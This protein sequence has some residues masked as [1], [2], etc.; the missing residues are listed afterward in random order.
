MSKPWQ[1][2]TSVIVSLETAVSYETVPS[3]LPSQQLTANYDDVVIDNY[4]LLGEDEYTKNKVGPPTA[5]I[6]ADDYDDI[7]LPNRDVVGQDKEPRSHIGYGKPAAP[8]PTEVKGQVLEYCVVTEGA[9]VIVQGGGQMEYDHL[10]HKHQHSASTSTATKPKQLLE[11]YSK[12]ADA[13]WGY[14]KMSA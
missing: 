3:Q 5:R 8:P 12:L 7:I 13:R 14:F 6:P 10:I 4:H 9:K 1:L 2:F 11:G